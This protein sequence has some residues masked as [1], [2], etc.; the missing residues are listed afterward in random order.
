MSIEKNLNEVH[1]GIDSLQIKLMSQWCEEHGANP[2]DN[3]ADA[4]WI[5]K[6]AAKYREL[7]ESDPGITEEELVAELYSDDA[8][9]KAA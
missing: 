1:A 7:I 9:K 3:S 6:Y 4:V 5:E 8:Y 2:F